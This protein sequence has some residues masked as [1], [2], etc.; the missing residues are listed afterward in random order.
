MAMRKRKLKLMPSLRV[1]ELSNSMRNHNSV[2]EAIKAAQ[3]VVKPNKARS[4][5]VIQMKNRRRTI[6][7]N[8]NLR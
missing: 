1:L 3:K 4:S 5:L 8:L 2:G 7:S 6:K